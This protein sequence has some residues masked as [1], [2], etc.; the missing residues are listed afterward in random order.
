MKNSLLR[1][2]LFLFVLLWSQCLV[3]QSYLR[4]INYTQS[5][6]LSDN[7]V[8]YVYQDHRGFIWIGTWSGLNRFDGF[9]FRQYT[10]NKNNPNGMLGNW[11]Y[12]IYEDKDQDLWVCTSAELMKYDWKSDQ[13]LKIKGLDSITVFDIEQDKKGFLWITSDH[14][15]V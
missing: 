5:N 10:S 6:G 14:G 9:N 7:Y 1:N 2:G 15:L 3:G 13:F 4:Y 11:I 12:K 8:N